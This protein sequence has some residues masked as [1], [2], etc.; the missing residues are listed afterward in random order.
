MGMLNHREYHE[1]CDLRAVGK[2][3]GGVLHFTD[4][5]EYLERTRAGFKRQSVDPNEQGGNR[6]DV[7]TV[8]GG[9]PSYGGRTQ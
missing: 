5:L 8:G 1:F 9:S 4:F 2:L 3:P 7:P 6:P